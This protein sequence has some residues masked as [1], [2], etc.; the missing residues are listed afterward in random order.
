MP[1]LKGVTVQVCSNGQ[2]LTEYDPASEEAVDA[3]DAELTRYIESQPGSKFLVR[4]IPDYSWSH[5]SGSLRGAGGLRVAVTLDGDINSI[6]VGK[7]APSS[8]IKSVVTWEKGFKH[9]RDFEFAEIKTS[10]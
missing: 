7:Y 8:D 5:P 10:I 3:S 6:M 9:R 2:A 4:I 1:T